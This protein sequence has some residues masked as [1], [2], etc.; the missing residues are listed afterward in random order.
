ILVCVCWCASRV[1]HCCPLCPIYWRSSSQMGQCAGG[2]TASGYC[3]AQVIQV[4]W[5]MVISPCKLRIHHMS[6]YIV[7]AYQWNQYKDGVGL[8]ESTGKPCPTASD[9]SDTLIVI[10]RYLF[11]RL[12]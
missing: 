1:V 2:W 12:V 5:V 8:N 10:V 11:L 9:F 7:N 6:A 3:V 4:K